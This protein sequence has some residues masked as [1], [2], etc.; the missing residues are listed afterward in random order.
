[1]DYNELTRKKKSEICS[2]VY[3]E[4]GIITHI[5]KKNLVTVYMESSGNQQNYQSEKYKNGL[6]VR[7]RN[8]GDD[9]G[10]LSKA[11]KLHQQIFEANFRYLLVR[12]NVQRSQKNDLWNMTNQE[13]FCVTLRKYKWRWIGQTLRKQ[14]T[15]LPYKLTGF[16]TLY[17]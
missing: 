14:T 10:K 2:S 9:R 15:E 1:M 5:N 11:M 8:L 17:L 4:S 13:A 6:D 3:D 7:S 16:A 12:K